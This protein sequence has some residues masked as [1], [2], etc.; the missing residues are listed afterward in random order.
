VGSV[1]EQLVFDFAVP[2]EGDGAVLRDFLRRALG[3]SRG[4]IRRVRTRGEARVDGAAAPL[5]A[6]LVAGARV[7]VVLFAATADG[8][9]AGAT[10]AAALPGRVV[11]ESRAVLVI[12][13]P[14]GLVTH[15]TRGYAAGTLVQLARAYLAE[16]GELPVVH[17]VH[18]LDR[19][20]SGLV[21][22]AKNPHAH[23]FLGGR[24]ERVYLAV[25][26][27][28]PPGAA[29]QGGEVDLPLGRE[30]G[31]PAR[32][33]PVPGGRSSRTL[34]RV[35]ATWRRAAEAG[36]VAGA[37]P[38]AGADPAAG[39]ARGDLLSLLEV[40]PLTGRTHQI[41]AHLTAIDCPLAGDLMY[42]GSPLAGL[43]RPALHAWK[44]AFPHPPGTG[45]GQGGDRRVA[46]VAPL[47]PDI[48]RALAISGCPVIIS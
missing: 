48:A 12:D 4:L 11:F 19:D 14:A 21:L 41:R 32:R 6:R 18:R 36:P 8:A 7:Q 29:D 30:P 25:V 46:V 35:L 43:D 27:G 26:E 10:D 1:Q 22:L 47:A 37:D 33:G 15:P 24:L 28:R 31:H 44:L 16:R 5:T 20:T 40:R 42:G 38:L 2:P 23:H 17:P 34:Y 9:T 13:K 45:D 3:A 39:S